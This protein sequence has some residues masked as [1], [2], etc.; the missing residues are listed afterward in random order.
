M[1]IRGTSDKSTQSPVSCGQPLWKYIYIFNL[2]VIFNWRIT[3]L[4]YCVGFS[5]ISA[6]IGRR[7]NPLPPPAPAHPLGC[8]KACGILP[9]TFQDVFAQPWAISWKYVAVSP[10]CSWRADQRHVTNQGRSEGWWIKRPE[11]DGWTGRTWTCLPGHFG[12]RQS[13]HPHNGP[14]DKAGI[15]KW[16]WSLE[17]K[18]NDACWLG[19]WGAD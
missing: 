9:S 1:S 15:V 2:N 11:A 17:K 10:K 4:Q 19:R 8:H 7:Y 5:R 14:P 18:K 6:W 3:A 12:C 13:V 16:A